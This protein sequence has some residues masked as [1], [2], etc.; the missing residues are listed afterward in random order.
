[1]A[2]VGFIT[3]TKDDVQFVTSPEWENQ[4]LDWLNR[5]MGSSSGYTREIHGTVGVR[6]NLLSARKTEKKEAVILKLVK[7]T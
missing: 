3:Y 5:E 2:R 6:C 4:F 7:D 1:M